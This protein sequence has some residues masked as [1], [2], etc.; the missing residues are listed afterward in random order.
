MKNKNSKK[1]WIKN[2]EFISFHK[3]S[4]LHKF[5]KLILMMILRDSISNIVQR[6]KKK[7]RAIP[8]TQIP[9]YRFSIDDWL[10]QLLIRIEGYQHILSSKHWRSIYFLAPLKLGH[11]HSM[12]LSSNHL[13]H[14]HK[15]KLF[16]LIGKRLIGVTTAHSKYKEYEV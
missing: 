1:W 14:E 11:V 9:W 16:S 7:S 8:N 10:S 15:I 3:I 13:R 2:I 5:L 4:F 6:I 12:V